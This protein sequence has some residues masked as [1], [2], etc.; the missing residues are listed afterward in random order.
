M[1]LLGICLFALFL[2]FFA[3]KYEDDTRF[4]FGIPFD[5]PKVC[6]GYG[7]CLING[8][9]ACTPGVTELDCSGVYC[10]GILFNDTAVCSSSGRCVGPDTCTCYSGRT[11]FNCEIA[12]PGSC[13][14]NNI[15]PNVVNFPPVLDTVNSVFFNDTLILV[16]DVPLVGGRLETNISIQN[17]KLKKCEYP[18][19]FWSQSLVTN[20]NCVNRYTAQIPW[21]FAKLC[22]WELSKNETEGTQLVFMGNVIVSQ[23][24]N[25]PI[26]GTTTT[27]LIQTPIGISV[28]F[29]TK[30]AISASIEV[31]NN[32]RNGNSL[33]N[34]FSTALNPEPYVSAYLTKQLY[35]LGPPQR[36]IFEFITKTPNPKKL[37]FPTIETLPPGLSSAGVFD[38]T[39]PDLCSPKLAY[40]IQK[41]RFPI[42]IGNACS[43]TGRY[44]VK[45]IKTCNEYQKECPEHFLHVQIQVNSE[46]LCSTVEL[47]V[48][49]NATL[50]GTNGDVI[51]GDVVGSGGA[52]NGGIISSSI[53]SIMN[54][55]STQKSKN[56]DGRAYYVADVSSPLVDVSKI[57]LKRLQ[58]NGPENSFLLVD[59]NKITAYGE[60]VK[61]QYHPSSKLNQQLFS[62]EPR[63]SD[64]GNEYEFSCVLDVE[65]QP[66]QSHK[67]L[68][69]KNFNQI[70][71]VTTISKNE[72]EKTSAKAFQI[73]HG[74]YHCN[75]GFSILVPNSFLMLILTAIM[76]LF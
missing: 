37:S 15:D 26:G 36:A 3:Q 62:L 25:V 38:F 66:F 60:S 2:L 5:S 14:F 34:F 67:I 7:I 61:F 47:A 68:K 44:K 74:C 55:L 29:Q 8:T 27:R 10:S 33:V 18:G 12:A 42:D 20:G 52:D 17:S 19:P 23:R 13:L 73:F 31:V 64:F 58:A 75:A 71:Q 40:C 45:F 32:N 28:T 16:I 51:S 70:M 65:Y 54:L 69:G 72:F 30:I 56:S 59:Q 50:N 57:N 41:W 76:L 53:S 48:G 35:I 63:E 39:T 43:L 21:E 1:K 22:G 24:E 11:G 49:L 46:D 9:C 6:N 4:C